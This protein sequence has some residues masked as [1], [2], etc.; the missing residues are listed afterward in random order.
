M[1]SIKL[2][3]GSESKEAKVKN[4]AFR[5]ELQLPNFPNKLNYYDN[6][7]FIDNR[8]ERMEDWN[9][10][11]PSTLLSAG[12]RKGKALNLKTNFESL[13]GSAGRI[14]V[15]RLKPNTTIQLNDGEDDLVAIKVVIDSNPRVPRDL[16]REATLLST[17][18]HPNVSYFFY[19]IVELILI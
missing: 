12:T 3:K 8:I 2:F 17:L 16:R 5:L 13:I 11:N 10:D 9:L 15:G 6:L 7:L 14:L 18:N 1:K 19:S 4:F